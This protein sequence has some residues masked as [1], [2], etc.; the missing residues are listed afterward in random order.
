MNEEKRAELYTSPGGKFIRSDS[1]PRIL[2]HW[3]SFRQIQK[4][5]H[6]IKY[7]GE[8]YVNEEVDKLQAMT[9]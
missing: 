5:K 4:Q 1:L 8:L 9:F 3:G 6:L 2:A 7:D